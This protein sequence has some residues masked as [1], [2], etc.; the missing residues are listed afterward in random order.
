MIDEIIDKTIDKGVKSKINKS[1]K[2]LTKLIDDKVVYSINKNLNETIDN[3]I[4]GINISNEIIDDNVKKVKN[5]KIKKIKINEK[6]KEDVKY[7]FDEFMANQ[8]IFDYEL[9]NKRMNE[10]NIMC[11]KRLYNI[12]KNISNETISNEIIEEKNASIEQINKLNNLQEKFNKNKKTKKLTISDE[13]IHE[14]ISIKKNRI[15]LK[16]QTF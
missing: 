4:E 6:L 5:K 11:D 10:I 16:P 2:D 14:K 15:M 12:E 8:K 9:I 7:V 3:K 13:Y 1:N